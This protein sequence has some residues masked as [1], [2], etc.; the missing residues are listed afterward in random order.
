VQL[1]TFAALG[2]CLYWSALQN[3]FYYDDLHSIQF[4][5]HIRSLDN[6]P[7][8]FSDPHT[9]SSRQAGYM[10]RPALLTSYALNYAVGGQSVVGYRVVNL[11]L[12]I[13]CSALVAS[14]AFALLKNRQQSWVAGLL[15]LMHPTHAEPINYISSRS[16]LLVSFA[17]MFVLW[18]ASRSRVTSWSTYAVYAL[19]L[20]TK[21]VAVVTPGLLLMFDLRRGGTRWR[22]MNGRHWG[23]GAM[24]VAYMLL[25]WANNFLA[26]SVSKAPRSLRCPTADAA[27]GDRLLPISVGV[28]SK[29]EC[30]ASVFSNAFPGAGAR[31]RIPPRAQSHNHNGEEGGGQAVRHMWKLVRALSP[32][33]VSGPSQHSRQ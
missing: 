13:V 4:N 24:T 5:P 18:M 28:S 15:F 7:S 22:G 14:L 3:P 20:L 2:F 1:F 25:I 19:G 11:L 23:F 31:S 16:D 9:F 32:A 12:H 26:S 8:F 30:G 29:A 17:V 6:I 33:R 10:F 21:S 27:Q